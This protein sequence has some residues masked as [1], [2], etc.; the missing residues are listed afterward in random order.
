[1]DRLGQSGAELIADFHIFG[2]QTSTA[3][4]CYEDPHG[5]ASQKS[6]VFIGGVAEIFEAGIERM[7]AFSHEREIVLRS[8]GRRSPQK[9][10]GNRP[11]FTS[12]RWPMMLG[13]S[14]R[15]G[16]DLLRRVS[17]V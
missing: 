11:D 1:V 2:A 17:P 3:R 6:W 15:H 5:A 14:V 10:S 9:A 13:Q 16:P 12:V 7:G 8:S 4:L